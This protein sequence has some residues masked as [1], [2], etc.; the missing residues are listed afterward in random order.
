M[1]Y[2]A[3]HF[4]RLVLMNFIKANKWLHLLL[5]FAVLFSFSCHRHIPKPPPPPKPHPIHFKSI[6]N[7]PFIEV[8]RRL[9]SGLSFDNY[10]FEAEPF[11]RIEFLSEDTARIFDPQDG[12]YYN[13][14]IFRETDS[15]FNVARSYFKMIQQSRD[16]I[17]LQVMQVAGDTLHLQRSLVYMTFYS[18]NYVQNV[19]HTTA[20]KLGRPDHRDTL[21]ILRKSEI[22]NKIPDSAFAARQPATLTSINPLAKVEQNVV[23]AEVMNNYDASD[24]YMNPEF[25]ITINKAYENFSYSFWAFVDDKGKLLFDHSDEMIEPEFK[26]STNKTLKGIVD[27][28]LSYYL[29]VTPG[30]TL[31]IKHTSRILLNVVGRTGK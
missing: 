11:Y 24:G 29:K 5:L 22:A 21:F 7:I 25:N 31:G 18:K 19:L 17:R 28:Y 12:N 10:G 3:M 30:S 6:V 1:A 26:E 8:K 4:T 13:F 14:Y 20:E 27:G 23:K 9:K 15:I 2:I 16:S